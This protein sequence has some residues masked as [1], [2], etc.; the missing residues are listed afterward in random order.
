[1]PFW[2]IKPG[3][4]LL[5][6]RYIIAIEGHR[7][8]CQSVEWIRVGHN[9]GSRDRLIV[10]GPAFYLSLALQ[11][12]SQAVRIRRTINVGPEFG[13]HGLVR[14]ISCLIYNIL[15][16]GVCRIG[17]GGPCADAQIDGQTNRPN[18]GPQACWE[19]C[20]I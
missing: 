14:V 11:L 3:C 20:Q 10:G 1:M 19:S 7:S 5:S 2:T 15:K 16:R 17:V 18:Y 6:K 8:P 12:D 9:C 4:T 13:P